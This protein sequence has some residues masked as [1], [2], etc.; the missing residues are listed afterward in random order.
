MWLDRLIELKKKTGMSNKQIADK[1]FMSEKTVHRIFNGENDNPHY[2]TLDR[3]ARALG[4]TIE[5]ICSDSNVVI[6]DESL[7]SLQEKLNVISAERDLISA[8]N[9][10]LK[11]KV[12]SLTAELD[13]LNMQLKHK[14]EIIALHNYYIKFKSAEIKE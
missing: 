5:Y 9:A 11:D 10:I 3:I 14:E 8:E 12:T 4:S 1:T 2:D 13:L 7:V 6:G